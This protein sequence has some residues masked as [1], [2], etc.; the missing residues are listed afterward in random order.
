MKEC[1]TKVIKFRLHYDVVK[2][3]VS[4]SEFQMVQSFAKSANKSVSKIIKQGIKKLYGEYDGSCAFKYLMSEYSDTGEKIVSASMARSAVKYHIFDC[5]SG[6]NVIKS[7]KADEW[8]DNIPKDGTPVKSP[9]PNV[10]K[11]YSLLPESERYDAAVNNITNGRLLKEYAS[12]LANPN[13]VPERAND[14][15]TLITRFAGQLNMS[16]SQL[17][18]MVIKREVGYYPELKPK[19]TP[20]NEFENSHPELAKQIHENYPELFNDKCLSL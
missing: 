7:K 1:K 15:Y 3:R 11:E 13:F 16:I 12:L 2:C 14:E 9:E 17:I 10:H 5:F 18:R 8:I 4:E 6:D 20:L 19:L